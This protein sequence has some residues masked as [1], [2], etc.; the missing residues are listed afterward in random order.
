MKQLY[1]TMWLLANILIPLFLLY[2]SSVYGIE[3]VLWALVCYLYGRI[4]GEIEGRMD[5]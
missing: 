1:F 5:R 4:I 3:T 2:A